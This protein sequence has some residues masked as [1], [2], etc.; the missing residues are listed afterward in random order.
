MNTLLQKTMTKKKY[1]EKQKVR[2]VLNTINTGTVTHSS[3]TDYKRFTAE[4]RRKAI[5]ENS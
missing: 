4:D 3:K 2:R 5:D 1:K